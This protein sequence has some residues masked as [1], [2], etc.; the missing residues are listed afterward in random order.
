LKSGSHNLLEPSGLVQGCNGI[1]FTY[2][3]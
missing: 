1:P 2:T 3:W